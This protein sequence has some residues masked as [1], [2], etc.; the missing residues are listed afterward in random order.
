MTSFNLITALMALFS[1]IVTV[2]LEHQHVDL[3]E[4]NTIQSITA[5]E[6]HSVSTS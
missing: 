5:R 1:N 6:R 3:G 2:K 4:G